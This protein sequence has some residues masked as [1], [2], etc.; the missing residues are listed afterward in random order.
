MQTGTLFSQNH[1]SAS[2]ARARKEGILKQHAKVFWMC[3]LSGAGKST[4]ATIL[5]NELTLRGY[6]CR[7]IDGDDIRGGLNKGLGFSEHDRHENLRRVAEVAKLFAGTG[8][9]PIVSFI[10]PTAAMRRMIHDTI[11]DDY[12]EIFID[13]P[14]EICEK[15]DIKGLYKEARAGKIHNFTGIDSPFEPPVNPALRIDT[16][17]LDVEQSSCLLLE[18]V[19]PMIEYTK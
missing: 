17:T 11:G 10:T 12:T 3:G 8:V 6:L 14:L 2:D 13:A 19:L 9:I 4:L 18:F 1:V 5:D 7:I 15:R 16:G